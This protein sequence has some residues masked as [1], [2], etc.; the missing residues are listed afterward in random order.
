MATAV[1]AAL[2]QQLDQPAVNLEQLV[3]ERAPTRDVLM[4]PHV[5]MRWRDPSV[6]TQP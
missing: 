2:G 3:G 6:S 5:T 1:R 4:A